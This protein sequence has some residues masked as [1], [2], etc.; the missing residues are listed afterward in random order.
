MTNI[1][2][3]TAG[4]GGPQ[5]IQTGMASRVQPLQTGQKLGVPA[6][7]APTT[8]ARPLG[9]ADPASL[10]RAMAEDNR[11][12]MAVATGGVPLGGQPGDGLTLRLV[13]VNFDGQTNGL[14]AYSQITDADV[15]A[16]VVNLTKFQILT[17][18][19]VSALAQANQ[20][21]QSVL[22]LLR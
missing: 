15:A 14:G 13:Q 5:R 10:I 12:R 17:Q 6:D 16:E 8:P 2:N 18:S 9:G 11:A 4:S 22:S 19:G 3:V 20:S 1:L 21:S 7:T